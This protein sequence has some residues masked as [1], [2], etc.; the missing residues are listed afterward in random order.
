MLCWT[1]FLLHAVPD[2]RSLASIFLFFF[3][4]L[5]LLLCLWHHDSVMWGVSVR[6][7]ACSSCSSRIGRKEW[8]KMNTKKKK[9]LDSSVVVFYPAG[10]RLSARTRNEEISEWM[11][12][13]RSFFFLFFFS[14]SLSTYCRHVVMIELQLPLYLVI[15]LN[16]VQPLCK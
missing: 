5:L 1:A 12:K 2:V 9:N 7:M 3:L 13:K 4:L 6:N 10:I 14:S 11:R 16:G 8:V 15:M